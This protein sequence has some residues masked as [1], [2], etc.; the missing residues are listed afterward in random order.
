MELNKNKETELFNKKQECI[1]YK[2]NFINTFNIL[3]KDAKNISEKS[4]SAFDANIT[5]TF[6]S[7]K[8]NSCIFEVSLTYYIDDNY[9]SLKLYHDYLSWEIFDIQNICNNIPFW[10]FKD[11]CISWKVK[12]IKILD[13][14]Q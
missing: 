6:Y 12:K 13:E 14:I 10:T 5:W 8:L 4:N 1:K 3:Y 11:L 7:N 9:W 2:S